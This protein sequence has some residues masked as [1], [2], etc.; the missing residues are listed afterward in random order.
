MSLGI[1][2]ILFPLRHW[3]KAGERKREKEG[4]QERIVGFG[5][6][7]DF[8]PGLQGLVAFCMIYA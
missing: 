1:K 8:N 3:E 5:R 4:E 6:T 2:F 7:L